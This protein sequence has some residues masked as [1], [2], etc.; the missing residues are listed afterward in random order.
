MTAS[1]THTFV[2]G[3]ADDVDTSLVRP[4]D[5]N[6]GHTITGLPGEE[7]DYVQ[8]TTDTSITQ[9]A[10]ASADTIVTSS[11][12]SYDG[13]TTVIIEFYSWSVT[14]QATSSVFNTVYLFADGSS[15]GQFG[16]V[17]TVA[18]VGFA[19][20]M[21]VR[22]RITP[23]AGSHTYSVRATTTS[24]TSTVGGGAGTGT[25]TPQPAYIRITRV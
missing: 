25:N 5:W 18:G 6:A 14:T 22:R 19:A 15:I 13:S 10:E 24:G 16:R 3:I 17:R 21:L 1:V 9:T 20:S 23:S 7:L 4:S 11:T 12:L 8:K 2:S